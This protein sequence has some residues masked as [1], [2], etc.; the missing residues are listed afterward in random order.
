[1]QTR[2]RAHSPQRMITHHAIEDIDAV[3]VVPDQAG[4]DS[5]QVSQWLSPGWPWWKSH[6]PEHAVP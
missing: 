1:M 2:Q 6:F 5:L 3:D 4:N